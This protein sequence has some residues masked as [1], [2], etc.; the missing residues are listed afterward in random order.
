MEP[1][2]GLAHRLS[3]LEHSADNVKKQIEKEGGQCHT[4]AVDLMQDENCEKVVK[5]HMQKYGHLE[6]LVNNVGAAFLPRGA[7]RKFPLIA[8]SNTGF[9]A[10]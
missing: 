5:E 10:N 7:P 8:R 3:L 9:Q 6:V 1:G 4:V 2:F